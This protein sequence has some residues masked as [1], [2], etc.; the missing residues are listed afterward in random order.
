MTEREV[1][2]ARK[3]L[4]SAAMAGKGEYHPNVCQKCKSPCK[5]G[6]RLLLCRTDDA[7]EE[8]L[9]IY[10]GLGQAVVYRASECEEKATASA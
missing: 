2:M 6:T 8:K 4:C 9:P 3:R 7:A 5:Y 10:A 1:Q